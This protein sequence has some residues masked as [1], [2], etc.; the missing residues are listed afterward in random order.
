VDLCA[1]QVDLVH[2]DWIE[3]DLGVPKVG[4]SGLE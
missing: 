1:P 2:L 3:V 4:V